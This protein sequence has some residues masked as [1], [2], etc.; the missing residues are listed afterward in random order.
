MSQNWPGSKV[1]PPRKPV[2]LRG[3]SATQPARAPPPSPPRRWYMASHRGKRK[4]LLPVEHVLRVPTRASNSSGRRAQNLRSVRCGVFAFHPRPRVALGAEMIQ[5]PRTA[6]VSTARTD[7][8]VRSP[9]L[10]QGMTRVRHVRR[11]AQLVSEPTHDSHPHRRFPTT[12]R[13][14][15]RRRSSSS[16]VMPAYFVGRKRRL[17][18][19]KTA[20]SSMYSSSSMSRLGK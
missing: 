1:T 17:E 15:R 10:R 8:S 13:S 4:R 7:Q 3:T 20:K 2:H 19:S 9:V 11:P 6:F 18:A 5:C 16:G 12:A 14:W